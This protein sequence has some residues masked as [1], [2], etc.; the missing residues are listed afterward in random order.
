MDKAMQTSKKLLGILG[1]IVPLATAFIWLIYSFLAR[2][3]ARDLLTPLIIGGVP[4]IFIYFRRPIDKLLLPVQPILRPIPKVLRYI[5]SLA[6]PVVLGY[7]LA[8]RTYSGYGIPR[9]V[10]LISLVVGYILICTPEVK[11]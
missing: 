11:R 1:L 7:V 8:A 10:S 5:L 2:G 4:L 6:L 9:I 3:E